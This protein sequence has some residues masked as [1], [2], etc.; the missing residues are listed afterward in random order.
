MCVVNKAEEVILF[1]I[2]VWGGVS[3]PEG[4][5]AVLISTA[6]GGC[7]GGREGQAETIKGMQLLPYKQI[8]KELGRFS[9]ERKRL[10]GD[11]TDVKSMKGMEFQIKTCCTWTRGNSLK[12]W[13]RMDC[14]K[15]PLFIQEI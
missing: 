9:L 6:T 4:L 8:L 5:H 3:I 14:R 12:C 15:Y 11:K 10:R 7:S 13:F 2:K 1:L